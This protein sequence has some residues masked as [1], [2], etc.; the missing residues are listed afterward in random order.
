MNKFKAG[1]RVSWINSNG[2]HLGIRTIVSVNEV[3]YSN[4]GYG[5]KIEPTDTPWFSI[6][7]EEFSN[8]IK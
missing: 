4:S 7:E 3:T 6:P 2:V 1:E 5:Y 8:L